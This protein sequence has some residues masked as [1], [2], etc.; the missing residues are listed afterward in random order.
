MQKKPSLKERLLAELSPRAWLRTVML[1]DDTPH[2]IALGVAVGLFIGTTPTVGLQIALVMLC[3]LFM[4]GKMRM[5]RLAA[6]AGTYISNPFTIVPL[7]W[8]CYQVGRL[9]TTA[10]VNEEEFARLIKAESL[11][12]W[13]T[14]ANEII[15]DI[16]IPLLL[17]TTVVGLI[18]GVPS[19]WIVKP[20]VEKFQRNMNVE[21]TPP[22]EE[23][24][25]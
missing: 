24:V 21:Q 2:A 15:Y 7:Y 1:I 5:N 22:R 11:H 12:E 8:M 17:G 25:A 18:L 19:Y 4:R 10:E 3:S 6:I 14:I 13:W 20:L 16:G 9:F 23:S